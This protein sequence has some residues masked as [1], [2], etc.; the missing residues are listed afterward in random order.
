MP[1]YTNP[2]LFLVGTA[3][4]AQLLRPSCAQVNRLPPCPNNTP[5]TRTP[6]THASPTTPTRT[7][8]LHTFNTHAPAPSIKKQTRPCFGR[9]F[10]RA[11]D[12]QQ[13]GPAPF[14]HLQSALPAP[15]PPRKHTPHRPLPFLPRTRCATLSPCNANPFHR[16]KKKQPCFFWLVY[17]RRGRAKCLPVAPPAL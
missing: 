6:H 12:R 4:T 17:Q 13:R 15:G 2:A 9:P 14:Q 11:L 1:L 8:L 7:H 3:G 10:Q 5:H 16:G